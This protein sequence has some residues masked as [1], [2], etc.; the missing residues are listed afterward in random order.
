MSVIDR[1]QVYGQVTIHPY[2][3][4]MV[5]K[6]S[7]ATYIHMNN[8]VGMYIANEACLLDSIGRNAYLEQCATKFEEAEMILE[9]FEPSD[10]EEYTGKFK[11]YQAYL[12]KL[13]EIAWS[14]CIRPQDFLSYVISAEYGFFAKLNKELYIAQYI[15]RLGQYR[16][17]MNKVFGSPTTCIYKTRR[18]CFVPANKLKTR[19]VIACSNI[20]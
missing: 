11:I 13:R 8:I 1:N 7:N 10:S 4:D 16:D 2:A 15:A 12:A 17:E 9:Y 3:H 14:I 19:E 20:T 5:H 6:I 18:Q